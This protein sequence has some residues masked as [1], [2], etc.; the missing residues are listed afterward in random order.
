[1]HHL[2]G[3]DRMALG[4]DASAA[5]HGLR[6]R[7]GWCAVSPHAPLHRLKAL[8]LPAQLLLEA[9]RPGPDGRGRVIVEDLPPDAELVNVLLEPGIGMVDLVLCSSS[10]PELAL[11]DSIPFLVPHYRTALHPERTAQ[12]GPR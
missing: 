3:V 4:Q 7:P 8:R 6:S 1:M 9:L 12:G 10:F 5:L 2:R 11:A